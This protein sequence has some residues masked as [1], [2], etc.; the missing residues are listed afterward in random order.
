VSIGTHP[1]QKSYS[2]DC[3]GDVLE[4]GDWVK[5]TWATLVNGDLPVLMVVGVVDDSVIEPFG[6]MFF[7][8]SGCWIDGGGDQVAWRRADQVKLVRRHG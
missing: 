2:L 3:D 1:D 6:R 5:A 4:V 7:N 8:I